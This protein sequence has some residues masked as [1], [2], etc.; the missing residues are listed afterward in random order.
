MSEVDA[1]EVRRNSSVDYGSV[2][3]CMP[4]RMLNAMKQQHP[5]TVYIGQRHEI[6]ARESGVRRPESSALQ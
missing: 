4:H 1:I 3:E 6:N 2:R 5:R